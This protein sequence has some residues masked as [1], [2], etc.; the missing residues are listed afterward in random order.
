MVKV[1]LLVVVVLPAARTN[2]GVDSPHSPS[3]VLGVVARV[4]VAGELSDDELGAVSGAP[5]PGGKFG[6]EQHEASIDPA[7]EVAMAA[8]EIERA[9]D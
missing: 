5:S 8:R 2:G 7:V 4:P 9:N 1:G 6:I 3:R